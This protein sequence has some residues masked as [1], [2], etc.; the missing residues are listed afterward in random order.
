MKFD[1]IIIGGGLSGLICGIRL[2][3]KG[4]DCVVVTVGQSA[5]YFFAG[6]FDLIGK[7]TTGEPV[8]HPLEAVKTLAPDH[9]Y[10][11]MGE[12]K[13]GYHAASFV[14]MINKSGI[15]VQGDI[16]NNHHFITAMGAIKKTWLTMTDFMPLQ[17]PAE[18]NGKKVALAGLNGFQDFFPMYIHDTLTR[19]G[20]EVSVSEIML[21]G[22]ERIR[23]N[24][25]EMRSVN[26]AQLFEKH[27]QVE[28]L[29]KRLK[30]RCDADLIFLPAVCGLKDQNVLKKIR[31]TLPIPI[32]CLPTMYPSVPGIRMENALTQAFLDAG[33]TL[34]AG[35]TV[36]QAEIEGSKVRCIYTHNHDNM[37]LKANNYVLATGHIFSKGLVADA[38]KISEPIFGSD[39]VYD[40]D[41]MD[42]SLPDLFAKQ[43]FMAYGVKTLDSM[44]VVRQGKGMDNLFAAGSILAGQSSIAEQSGAGVA[45]MSA[46]EVA[47]N[48]ANTYR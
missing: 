42:W 3:Q 1:T 26:I 20:A 37:P 28:D 45:I 29:C 21:P 34:L 31:E 9:L 46:M 40:A 47:E 18:L 15:S 48:I 43:P 38:D 2:Q 36:T 33:G 16:T 23:E 13:L 14:E 27:G 22:L 30:Q 39:V 44:Q 8:M 19:L 4:H 12:E 17:D 5:L 11:R 24:V 41:R 32:Y 10:R 7:T 25:T 6:S 35:D